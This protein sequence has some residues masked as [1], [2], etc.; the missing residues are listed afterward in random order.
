[1]D[2]ND[3]HSSDTFA[4][5]SYHS[6]TVERTDL[7]SGTNDDD[8][9]NS[10]CVS[11]EEDSQPIEH[12]PSDMTTAQIQTRSS[13]SEKY[14]ENF[15]EKYVD[16]AAEAE[17]AS[18]AEAADNSL[19]ATTS[20]KTAAEENILIE[21]GKELVAKETLQERFNN[22]VNLVSTTFNKYTQSYDIHDGK[23]AE[24]GIQ[25]LKNMD[26]LIARSPSVEFEAFKV[27]KDP[28]LS[29]YYASDEW[30]S[31]LPATKILVSIKINKIY[32]KNI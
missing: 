12:Y 27:P 7:P 15:M 8:E 13:D 19:I 30:L 5:A 32:E 11:F 20:A 25:N 28:F 6:Q 3:D 23:K 1:M 14:V 21:T 4:S 29:P 9:D 26:A 10:L 16:V 2:P 24:H 22:A 31:Q 17:N 18:V